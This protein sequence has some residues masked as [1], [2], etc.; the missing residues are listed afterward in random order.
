MSEAEVERQRLVVEA[1]RLL[2]CANSLPPSRPGYEHLPYRRADQHSSSIAKL[3]KDGAEWLSIN[4]DKPDAFAAKPWLQV[5]L[6]GDGRAALRW[7]IE[8]VIRDLK[9]VR[10][11]LLAA[12]ATEIGSAITASPRSLRM[13]TGSEQGLRSGS[14]QSREGGSIGYPKRA[15]WLEAQLASRDWSAH[16]LQAQGGPD[17]K[18]TRKI[19]NGLP[20]TRS[21]LEKT[22]AAL[23][24]KNK[25]VLFRDI[26]QE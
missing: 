5:Q 11:A 25:Q 18:T 4:A 2:E 26:P 1:E 10:T 17:W 21:V 19:L 20:V 14:R 9:F 15:A 8:D 23:S 3:V 6:R 24:K 13:G 12:G 7:P 22:A 16:D